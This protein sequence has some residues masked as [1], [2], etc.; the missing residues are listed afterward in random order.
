MSSSGI[1]RIVRA[2]VRRLAAVA[3]A[4]ILVLALAGTALGGLVSGS[5]PTSGFTYTSRTIHDVNIVGHGIHLQTKGPVDVK[6]TY[7]RIAPTGA[8]LG[9][10]F[11]NGP[12][13]VSVAVGT[14]T[15]VDAACRHWDLSAG[16]GYIESTGEVLNAYLDPA[17]NSGLSSVEWFTTRL[18]PSGAADPVPVDA[19]C[20]P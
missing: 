4:A 5:L 11:H 2:R 17:K 14:I 20:I 9:W 18:Y 15:Y 8:M 13:I 16:Q 6:T 10:H 12:V 3:A 7:S 1:T 19:P